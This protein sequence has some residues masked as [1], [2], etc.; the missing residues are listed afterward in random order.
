MPYTWDRRWA[1][2]ILWQILFKNVKY[3]IL[4]ET[5]LFGNVTSEVIKEFTSIFDI[6]KVT[7]SAWQRIA[8]W[9]L[10]CEAASS[11][12]VGGYDEYQKVKP[13]VTKILWSS[14]Q[15]FKGIIDHILEESNGQVDDEVCITASFV[16]DSSESYYQPENFALFEN[17]SNYFYS[18][19]ASAGCA[20]SSRINQWLQP[21]THW[22][23]I[24]VVGI[25]T[26]RGAGWLK[27]QKTT[28]N[29]SYLISK[30]TSLT[31]MNAIL[32]TFK[33]NQENSRE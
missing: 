28:Q 16:L 17:L 14:G 26:R 24:Q 1:S 12:S 32:F 31:W 3:S 25:A 5:V 6:N 8:K 13:R 11:V 18:G 22:N 29:E 33:I 9:R 30:R 15:E 7:S 2:Q 21:V 4:Y 27:D 20:L 23:H 19:N 10:E